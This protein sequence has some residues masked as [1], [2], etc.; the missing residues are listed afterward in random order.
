MNIVEEIPEQESKK[1]ATSSLQLQNIILKKLKLNLNCD[2]SSVFTACFSFKYVFFKKINR[3]EHLH[4]K[5]L[6][7]NSS[8]RIF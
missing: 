5:R 2:N 1:M 3:F 8:I 4:T 6:I 7:L